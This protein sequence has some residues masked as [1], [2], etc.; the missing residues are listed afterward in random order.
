V[1]PHTGAALP[2][3]PTVGGAIAMLGLGLLLVA[4]AR[5]RS[6]WPPH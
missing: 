3:G 5:R 4:A 6:I 2:V 1:L